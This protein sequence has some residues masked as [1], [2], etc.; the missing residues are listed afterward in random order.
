[1]SPLATY[2]VETSVT[3][4]AVVAI[5]IVVLMGAKRLGVGRPHGP[6]HLLGRM[7]LDARRVVYLV[8]VA[9]QVLILG[10]SE[11]GLTKLG[12]LQPQALEEGESEPARPAFA[13][14][15]S[16]LRGKK[17]EERT[18]TSRT[19]RDGRTTRTGRTTSRTLAPKEGDHDA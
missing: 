4:L 15:L 19:A 3:L 11:A 6:M 7:P 16:R 14:L 8:R 1:M 17:A 13:D 2:L 18:D 12:E 10:A 9:D 5:A